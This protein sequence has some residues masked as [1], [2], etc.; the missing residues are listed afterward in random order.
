MQVDPMKPKLKPLRIRLLMLKYD[1]TTLKLRFQFKLRRYT[2]APWVAPGPEVW[3]PVQCGEFARSLVRRCRLEPAET[4]VKS[5]LVS[6][7][8]DPPY[9]LVLSNS[10]QW[11]RA[12]MHHS[13]LEPHLR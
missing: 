7:M 1:P 8:G 10:D 3:P 2:K 9:A 12:P 13:A 4:R 6:E 11:G 5:E